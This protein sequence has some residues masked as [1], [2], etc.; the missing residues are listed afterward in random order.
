MVGVFVF[1]PMP[2]KEAGPGA[3]RIVFAFAS[4]IA[5]YPRWPSIP[6]S[7]VTLGVMAQWLIVE[8]ALGTA[9]GLMVSFIA[10]SLT[11]GAQILGQQAGYGYASVVDPTTQADSDVQPVIANLAGG[12]LFFT[13]GLH[14]YIIRAFAVSLDTYPPGQFAVTRELAGAVIKLASNVFSVGIRLALPVLGLLLMTEIAM[15]LL[16]RMSSQL[17]IGMQAFPA[18]MLLTLLTL[19]SILIILPTLYQSFA[20]VVLENIQ[21]VIMR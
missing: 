20:T 7:N 10:E 16:G 5:L 8:G 3:A 1:I 15:A 18:K 9:I 6:A 19:V 17:H 14:R 2:I 4:A 11:F 13:T 21:R 12:L